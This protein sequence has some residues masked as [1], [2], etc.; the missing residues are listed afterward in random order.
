[1]EVESRV[2]TR[3]EET[4][5][6]PRSCQW[7]CGNALS[8]YMKTREA[9]PIIKAQLI[10]LVSPRKPPRDRTFDS[11]LGWLEKVKESPKV[12]SRSRE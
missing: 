11:G 4:G 12:K 8:I 9:A 6:S 3:G 1:M 7:D 2:R 5:P 10:R